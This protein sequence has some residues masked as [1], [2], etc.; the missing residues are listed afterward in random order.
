MCCSVTVMIN[1]FKWGSLHH[2][3]DTIRASN[4][5]QDFTHQLVDL[6]L[7]DYITP[8]TMGLPEGTTRNLQYHL[9]G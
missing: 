3:R 8:I 6:K 2:C 1:K 9:Q 7:P 5:V 4:D